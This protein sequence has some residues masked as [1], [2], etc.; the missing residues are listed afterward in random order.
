[1]KFTAPRWLSDNFGTML[2]SFILAVTVW[3]AA[4]NDQDPVQSGLVPGNVEVEY[5]GLTDGLLIVD[6]GQDQV[7]VMIRAPD[8]VWSSLQRSDVEVLADITGLSAGTHTIDLEEIINRSAIRILLI[9]PAQV[10][11]TL[12]EA[13]SIQVPVEVVLSGL[14][15]LGYQ[16]GDWTV[17]PTSAE[18]SGPISLVQQVVMAVAEVNLTDQRED[19]RQD[20]TLVAVDADGEVI[21]GVT[22]DA[23]Q[24]SVVVNVHPAEGS[25]QVV[26]SPNIQG[27]EA[28]N[29]AGYFV[30]AIDVQPALVTITG[31][32]DD[33]AVTEGVVETT[34]IDISTAIEDV[35]AQVQLELPEGITLQDG[36]QTVQVSIRIEAR[37]GTV[38][39]PIEVLAEGLTPGYF[40]LFSPEIVQVIVTG[41]LPLLDVLEEG[42]VQ[43]FVNLEDL[44]IGVHAVETEVI[45]FDERLEFQNPIPAIIQ[46]TIT[47]TP[48][49]TP[50]ATLSPSN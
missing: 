16:A 43:V 44:G 9:E 46:V 26:V 10:T 47:D 39:L 6:G 36:V 12:E 50:T 31:E 13:A 29:E 23:P 2:L 34:P 1:M 27:Q 4:V 49:P 33:L 28:L 37:S 38:T 15:P 5:L 8:S 17:D 21:E 20:V 32:P 35:I 42:H 14:I 40:A 22:I 18:V 3:V 48:P 24:A 7:E 19:I 30:A 11:L 41:P 45:V 25:K